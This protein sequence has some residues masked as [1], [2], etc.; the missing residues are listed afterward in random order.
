MLVCTCAGLLALPARAQE[1][2]SL[3][4]YQK[5]VRQYQKISTAAKPDKARAAEL[6]QKLRQLKTVSVDGG[7]TIAV[8]LSPD[9]DALTVNPTKGGKLFET[10]A[11]R[12]AT[13]H[14]LVIPE[15]VTATDPAKAPAQAAAILARAEFR[16]LPQKNTASD[17]RNSFDEWLARQKRAFASWWDSLFPAPKINPGG[18]VAFAYFVR[19]LLY[20]VAAVGVI[21]GLYYLAMYLTGKPWGGKKRTKTKG[22]G[23]GLDLDDDAF[24]DP[25][26]HARDL[27]ARGDYREAVRLVYIASLRRLAGSGLLTLQENRTNWEYQRT[28]RSRSQSAYD[29][30]LPG[31]RLFDRI[32][33]GRENA[34]KTEYEQTV[35][36]HDGLPAP[37]ITT[38]ATE[39]P[40]AG[41]GAD[42]GNS[43]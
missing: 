15:G 3:D 16:S 24:P 27:A 4:E 29:T 17:R 10:A 1:T 43:W 34:T 18:M 6:A 33:Y 2:V 26:G 19:F 38:K 14:S 13:L 23:T 28:L 5:L 30:L 37:V 36:L 21:I 8:D 9:A 22:G 31:T 20:F 12:S 40:L 11:R 32:W 42:K 7:K 41:A 35:A 39:K 25:L